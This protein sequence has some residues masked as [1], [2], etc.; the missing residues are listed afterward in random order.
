M[1]TL[2]TEDRHNAQTEMKDRDEKAD[3]D[4]THPEYDVQMLTSDTDANP[5]KTL[6]DGI[7]SAAH[8]EQRRRECE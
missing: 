5:I 2:A 4:E 6:F 1:A 3:S 8:E 7:L